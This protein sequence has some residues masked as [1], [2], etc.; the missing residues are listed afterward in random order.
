[1]SSIE[2]ISFQTA[3]FLFSLAI[4]HTS[5]DASSFLRKHILLVE[6][7]FDLLKRTQKHWES[8]GPTKLN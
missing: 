4:F 5:N 6:S 3:S 7:F 1:M 8:D 2:S